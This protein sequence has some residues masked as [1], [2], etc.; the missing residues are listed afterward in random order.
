M[1]QAKAADCARGGRRSWEV[2]C[3]RDGLDEALDRLREY[4][5]ILVVHSAL[6]VQ[7]RRNGKN[8]I[9]KLTLVARQK[10]YTVSAG[11]QSSDRK[12]GIQREMKIGSQCVGYVLTQIAKKSV[13]STPKKFMAQKWQ[14]CCRYSS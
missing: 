1:R 7:R 14:T 11:P 5:L 6:G 8:R 12:I 3:E 10:H 4:P 9:A 2:R 13:P